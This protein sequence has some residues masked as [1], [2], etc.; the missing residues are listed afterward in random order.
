M[1]V[2]E[3]TTHELQSTIRVLQQELAETNR[4]VVALTLELEKR[5]EQRTAELEAA[6]KE[7]EA[8]SYSISHDLRAPLRQ[9]DGFSQLLLKGYMDLLPDRGQDFLRR[10]SERARFMGQLIDDLLSFSRMSRQHLNKRPVK[11]D[12][13]V[14]EVLE[15]LSRE[16]EG[17]NVEIDLKPLPDCLGDASLLRQVYVNLL[18]NAFKFTRQ[19]EKAV[20]EIGCLAVDPELVC[21]V[22]DNGAG[23]DMRY[24]Q[25]LFGVFQRLHSPS[26]FEGTGVGLSIVRRIITRHGGRIWA[27]AEPDNGAA[28][29][30]TLPKL[31]AAP[32]VSRM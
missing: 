25:K 18:S 27:E 8:F 13:I 23:F 29:Y 4:E 12:L 26:E 10:V 22:R 3:A 30:F 20:I 1:K 16:R 5:V 31:S 2:T 7:L 9:I 11:L 28:F 24:A 32:A 17:R 21:Y 15:E 14:R 6:N 19:K